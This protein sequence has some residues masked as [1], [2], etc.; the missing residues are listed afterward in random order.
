[1]VLKRILAKILRRRPPE[2]LF[3]EA[4]ELF[5]EHD[6]KFAYA[7]FK[8]AERGFA[9]SDL[10]MQQRS[11]ISAATCASFLELDHEAGQHLFRA[12]R[13]SISLGR[14]LSETIHHI[15]KAAKAM[16]STDHAKLN[17]VIEILA[18]LYLSYVASNDLSRARKVAINPKL[19]G[20]STTCQTIK[21]LEQLIQ[22]RSEVLQSYEINW[23]FLPEE[24]AT[25]SKN[26]NNVLKGYTSL[27]A[28]IF[29]PKVQNI[30]VKEPIEVVVELTSSQEIEVN[31]L[32]LRTGSKGAVVNRPTLEL[33][34]AKVLPNQ[35]KRY[36][37]H[38]EAHLSGEW[39]IGPAVVGYKVSPNL[40]FEIE[41][42]NFRLTVNEPTPVLNCEM[43]LIAAP[44]AHQCRL[45]VELE[46]KGPGTVEDLRITLSIPDGLSIIDGTHEKQLFSLAP[47]Q[48]FS[49]E[50]GLR[51]DVAMNMLTG[52]ELSI[53]INH[54]PVEGT[55][56]LIL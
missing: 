17:D 56:R 36:A 51:S 21:Q 32:S 22:E 27:N 43:N 55:T 52:K 13:L 42:A 38:V 30:D 7:L 48:S 45:I 2:E 29:P 6:Y 18:A 12:A 26:V 16:L 1:M 53:E 49:Y 4:R 9:G 23:D 31:Q 19:L 8:K 37:F 25:L 46:N 5:S 20:S 14:P 47:S 50:L 44:E 10:E 33:E 34:K 3:A 54:S 41:T 24:F 40:Q 28:I 39:M 35:P 15:D 11:T